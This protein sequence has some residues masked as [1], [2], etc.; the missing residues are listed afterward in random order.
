MAT[1]IDKLAV[2][3][4]HLDLHYRPKDRSSKVLDLV[5]LATSLAMDFNYTGRLTG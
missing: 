3:A 1:I 5:A 2:R 4:E